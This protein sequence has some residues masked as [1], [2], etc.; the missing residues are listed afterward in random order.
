MKTQ[1]DQTA[2][3]TLD[4]VNATI[5]NIA[6]LQLN[7][8]KKENAMN[9]MLIDIKKKNEPDIKLYRDKIAVLESQ[10]KEFAKKN[11]KL[12]KDKRSMDLTY[13]RVGYRSGKK[14]LKL[15]DSKKFTWEYFKE[16][17]ES[18]Y[19]VKYVK[20][21]TKLKKTEIINAVESGSIS[22]ET[23]TDVLKAKVSSTEQFFYKIDW[24]KI[25]QQPIEIK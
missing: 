2:L 9:E 4:D 6:V 17:L 19:G 10:L 16:K 13:G 15:L 21:T 3:N 24:D 8:D 1:T 11:K 12:F 20:V 25:R 5:L 7:A 14:A 22:Q 23:I 18:L